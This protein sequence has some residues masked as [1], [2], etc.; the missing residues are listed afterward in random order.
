MSTGIAVVLLAAGRG[1]RFGGGKLAAELGG[2]ALVLHAAGVLAGLPFARR[3]AVVGPGVPALG[4][5]GFDAVFAAEGAPMSASLAAGVRAAEGAR[6]VLIALGDMPLVPAAHL[7]ALV[8]GFDGDRIASSSGGRVMPPAI[9]GAR[10][11]PALMALQGDKGAAALLVGAP[12]VA[13]PAGAALDVDT[14]EDLARAAA[15]IG[16]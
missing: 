3:I 6:A 5:L 7:R 14:A 16:L 13:L 15:L 4:G 2:R 8:A 10:H 9:W 11:F 1:V 12:W